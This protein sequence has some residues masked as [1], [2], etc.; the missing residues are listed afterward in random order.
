MLTPALAP[1]P[2]TDPLPS[3][4]LGRLAEDERNAPTVGADSTLAAAIE[5]FQSNPQLRMVPVL[6]AQHRP[7]GA[8]FEKDIRRLLLNPYGHALLRN[9]AYG[10]SITP[11]L[12]ACPTAE[13]TTEIE[14]LVRTYRAASENEGMIITHHGRLAAVLTNRRLIE[15]AAEAELQVA[16][17]SL[18]RAR[19]IEAASERFE[20]QAASLAGSMTELSGLLERD[21]VSAAKR[22]EIAG[23]H[24]SAVASAAA[25]TSDN[26]SEIAERGR[27]LAR[28]FMLIGDNAGDARRAAGNAAALVDAGSERARALL[29][30][31]QSIDSVIALITEIASQVNLLALNATIEAA[32]AGEA[33]RGFTVVANEVKQL[34]TQAGNAA[35]RITAHVHEIREGID[36]FAAGHALVERAVESMAGLADEVQCAVDA[37]RL[38]T[39]A[40]AANV[41]ETSEASSSIQRDIEAI[42]STSQAASASARDMGGLAHQ[43]QAGAIALSDQ[44][45]AFLSAVREA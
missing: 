22:A 10:R 18:A 28:A 34:S 3:G 12:R 38:A 14:A 33:G 16:R 8:I 13:A 31:A 7:I 39:Q 35:A 40:I 9:P 4:L 29:R 24:A 44:V 5:L 36:A 23:E 37:Q 1:T 43:L 6:D 27:E 15:L 45:G 19:R 30:S 32:R 20:A 41:A 17:A 2:G 26:M 25:Q 42:G 11:H 21:A